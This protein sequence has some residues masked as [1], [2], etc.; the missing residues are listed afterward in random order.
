MKKTSP[1]A[2]PAV[3]KPRISSIH[4]V[5]DDAHI[6]P[7]VLIFPWANCNKKYSSDKKTPHNGLQAARRGAVQP[8]SR[9]QHPLRV[10]P[11]AGNI[12]T[13]LCLQRR[14]SA[15]NPCIL[16][17]P[18]GTKLLQNPPQS[19]CHPF[20]SRSGGAP[21]PSTPRHS[22]VRRRTTRRPSATGGALALTQSGSPRLSPRVTNYVNLYGLWRFHPPL[23]TSGPS[24][25]P[26]RVPVGFP[27]IILHRL[28]RTLSAA[29]GRRTLPIPLHI[30]TNA[31]T[32][33]T[34]HKVHQQFSVQSSG[35][36]QML[37]SFCFGFLDQSELVML[38]SVLERR[39]RYLAL[40]LC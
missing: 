24:S 8:Q 39:V 6:V 40:S 16:R 12:R 31:P 28:C 5:G 30:K 29:G 22:L 3:E 19:Q 33:F 35:F 17:S 37:Y 27:H 25:A 13:F 10:Y 2:T 4:F 26:R 1:P 7:W 9:L 32:K 18:H 36:C 15:P 34:K 20:R 11:R 23:Q 14:H 21:E 38:Y